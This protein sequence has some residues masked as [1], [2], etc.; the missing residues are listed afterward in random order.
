MVVERFVTPPSIVCSNRVNAICAGLRLRPYVCA[1]VFVR[2]W[3]GRRVTRCTVCDSASK[4]VDRIKFKLFSSTGWEQRQRSSERRLTGHARARATHIPFAAPHCRG[5]VG[6]GCWTTRKTPSAC[7]DRS[8]QRHSNPRQ[9]RA[10]KM[11]K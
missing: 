10:Y 8:R 11:L 2:S 1:C 6:C 7:G 9:T 4:D 5:W 3:S